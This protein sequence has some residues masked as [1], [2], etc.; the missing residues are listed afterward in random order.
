M[1]QAVSA[2]ADFLLPA[3]PFNR[4]GV[5]LASLV[6]GYNPS[7]SE[8]LFRTS[9]V[10]RSRTSIRE[11]LNGLVRS[12]KAEGAPSLSKMKMQHT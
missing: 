6:L 3:V 1:A 12:L 4:F 2:V 7:G 10:A 9:A 11:D 8:Y 5:Y